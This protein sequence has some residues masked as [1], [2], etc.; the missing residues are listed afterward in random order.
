MMEKTAKTR[1][2]KWIEESANDQEFDRRLNKIID[3]TYTQ[4]NYSADAMRNFVKDN[5]NL[6]RVQSAGPVPLLTKWEKRDKAV[7]VSNPGYDRH[8]DA[9]G[10]VRSARRQIK[11]VSTNPNAT[12]GSVQNMIDD[13]NYRIKDFKKYK[14]AFAQKK[15]E[16]IQ[17]K[18]QLIIN[19]MN[20]MKAEGTPFSKLK[21]TENLV[22]NSPASTRPSLPRNAKIGI[23]LGAGALSVGLG[24]Y[25]LNKLRKSNK[26]EKEVN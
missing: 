17:A 2:M 13:H 4:N 11:L 8:I 16:Q 15:R 6:K 22:K 18:K 1:Y 7:S 10:D 5:A 21:E 25:G 3:R 23:G 20:D 26:E 19:R 14:Q 12:T 9:L 24:A